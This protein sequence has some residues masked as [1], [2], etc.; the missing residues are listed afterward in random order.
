MKYA[1]L[2]ALLIS[3]STMPCAETYKWVNENGVV[4]YSQTPPP[5]KQAER[6]KLRNAGPSGGESSKS[7]L[8]HLRQKMADS[9]EDREL[10]KQKRETEKEELALR[11]ENCEAARSNL[12]NLQGLGQRLYRTGGEYRRLT[13]EERQGL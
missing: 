5:D 13:E 2:T 6:L 4:T 11:R 3:F 9:A 1:I 8:D 10:E 12:R 7:R